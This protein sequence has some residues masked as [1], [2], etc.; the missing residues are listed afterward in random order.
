MKHHIWA[1]DCKGRGAQGEK[2]STV[3]PGRLPGGDGTRAGG[4][5]GIPG[6]GKGKGV[7]VSELYS[8]DREKDSL[9]QEEGLE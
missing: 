5:K 9:D 2:T 6:G 1:S 4:G 3:T 8:W 7:S